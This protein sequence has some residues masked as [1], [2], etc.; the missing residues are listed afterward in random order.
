MPDLNALSPLLQSMAGSVTVSL[1]ASETTE[2]GSLSISY[3]NLGRRGTLPIVA[4]RAGGVVA[5]L[6]NANQA[7]VWSRTPVTKF[8]DDKVFR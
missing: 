5:T 6:A 3:Q 4:L 2:G 8:K 1:G 7:Q